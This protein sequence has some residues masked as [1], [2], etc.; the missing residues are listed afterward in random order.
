LIAASLVFGLGF[1]NFSVQAIQSRQ[2]VTLQ[3]GKSYVERYFSDGLGLAIV[4]S[5]AERHGGR[6]SVESAPDKGSLFSALFP[7]IDH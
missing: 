1:L 4:K 5:I 7:T 3:I 6:V 2:Q